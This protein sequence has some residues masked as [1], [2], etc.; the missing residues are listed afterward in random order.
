MFPLKLPMSALSSKD[1]AGA[2]AG[3]W[4]ENGPRYGAGLDSGYV[5]VRHPRPG[6]PAHGGL[7]DGGLSK[8][9]RFVDSPLALRAF[10]TRA[11]KAEKREKG[12]K[13]R[14]RPIFQARHPLNPH[15]LHPPF[16]AAQWKES[17]D[18]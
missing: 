9:L 16:A 3:L 7:R 11:K 12:E 18:G 15:L 2:K 17:F 1:M 6:T 13:G 14:K 10:W 4:N 8:F 5:E